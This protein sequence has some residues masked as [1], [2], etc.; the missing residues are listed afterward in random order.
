MKKTYKTLLLGL[1]KM[2]AQYISDPFISESVK[3]ATHAQ[4]ITDHPLFSFEAAV[5]ISQNALKFVDKNFKVKKLCLS[6]RD[7]ENPEEIEVLVLATPPINRLEVLAYFPNLK[8]LIIEKPIGRNKKESYEFAKECKRRKLITQVN[9]SRRTDQI[10]N[11]LQKGELSDLIGEIQCGFGVYG[12]GI[13]NYAIHTIDLLRMLVGEITSVQ[14]LNNSNSFQQGPL[15]NDLNLSFNIYIKNI[16]ITIIPID[17]NNYREGSIDLW[18]T[19]GRLEILQEG[20]TIRS[21]SM[22]KCRSLAGAYEIN[23]NNS[24]YRDT[25]YSD[26]MYYLYDDL[27]K[28]LS[29][30]QNKTASDIYSALENE[31]IID[32]IL[33]SFHCGGSFINL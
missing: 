13:L 21:T 12:N 24:I 27:A 32:S 30:G 29:S 14:A 15:E 25:G 31:N 19:K 18:G 3:Y 9:L 16:Q 23:S 6:V 22:D 11:L 8:A 1:G 28:S 10:M 17:F 5:D 4:V 2:G 7:I 33:K 26:A 20:L